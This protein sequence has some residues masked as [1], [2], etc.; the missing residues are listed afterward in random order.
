[1]LLLSATPAAAQDLLN[2]TISFADFQLNLRPYVTLPSSNDSI[3]NMT[4][5]SGDSSLFVTTE[6][7][8]IF[9]VPTGAG[10]TASA[11]KWFD[12]AAAVQSA[13]GR[14]VFG[15]SS[16][17]GLQSVAFHPDFDNEGAAGYGKLYT[18]YLESRPGNT[19]AHHYLG[20]STYGNTGAD[21]VLAEWTYDHDSGGVSSQSH[22][23]LFRVQM[24]VFDHPIKQA[25]F[26]PYAQ[27]GDDDYG[28][29]YLTHGDSNTKH[30]PNDDPQH[31]GNALGKM[32]RINPLQDGGSPYSIP[33]SNP[34][35]DSSDP[36]V[37]QEVYAYGFR[38]P[39]TFSFDRDASGAVHVLVGDIGRNNMEEVNLVLPGHNY[40]WT[41]REGT[42]VHDQAPDNSGGEGYFTGVSPLP[43]NEATLGYSYPVAQYDHD[44]P[45]GDRSSGNSIASGFVIQNAAEPRLNNLFLF[46]DFSSKTNGSA[47]RDGELFFSDFD[48]M[49]SAVTD[50]SPDDP[51]RDEPGELTQATVG[52]L[53][54]ALDHDNNPGTPAQV[55]DGFI[56]LLN[57]SRSDVR[58]GRGPQGEVYF[59]S[60]RNGVIYLATD[61]LPLAG[62]FNRDGQ[63]DAADYTVWRDTLG[64]AGYLLAA[65]ADLN[66]VVDQADYAVWREN[67]GAPSNASAGPSAAPEPAAA[68]LALAAVAASCPMTRWGRRPRC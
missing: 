48:E 12:V 19:S 11:T 38:N 30:S 49:L 40:G 66:G 18:T 51:S 26:N 9:T 41:E 17:R 3:V 47:A 55:Y 27:P 60:K 52:K 8:D 64:D 34:F 4:T 14:S 32:I 43:A 68:L 29:L 62:D 7:G 13:T 67:Y 10:G 50:L 1:M 63:V 61:T 21:G 23:E 20:D 6:E 16:Q 15:N 59:S 22:R 5:R 53:R 36:D 45:V 35:A 28:L 39:H 33:G 2:D 31:L 37:L 54:L 25:A 57:S 44:A 56:D 24:P 42:F 65:D 46:T 58:I